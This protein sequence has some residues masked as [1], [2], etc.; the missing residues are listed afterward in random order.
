MTRSDTEH[1]LAL[2][3]QYGDISEE[4]TRKAASGVSRVARP[5]APLQVQSEC[6]LSSMKRER[7]YREIWQKLETL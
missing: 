2:I 5:S 6:T 1:I 4:Y 7:V 3:R